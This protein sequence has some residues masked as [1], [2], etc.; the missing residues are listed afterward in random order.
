M[1]IGILIIILTV[2]T[3]FSANIFVR[4]Q[5]F[6]TGSNNGTDWNNAY[7]G[8]T[9]I[10][11]ASV[12]AGD[13]I[14]VAGGTYTQNLAPT[15]TG[16]SGSHI[17][18]SRARSDSTEC[19]S[20]SGW[21]SGFD[22]LITQTGGACFVFNGNYDYIDITGKTTASG[23]TDNFANY[24]WKIDM[25]GQT[26]GNG[27][28]VGAGGSDNCSLEWI[29]FQGVGEINVTGDNRAIDFT[30]NSTASGGW[31]FSHLSIHD[32]ESGVYLVNC[33]GGFTFEWIEMYDIAPLNT[34]TFHPN[35]IITWDAGDATVR[36]SKFHK[37]PNGLACG[38]GVFFEQS[39]GSTG[40]SIY[41]NIFYDIDY[42]GVKAIEITSAVGAIKIY[43]NTFVNVSVGTIYTSDSPSATGGNQVNNFVYNTSVSSVTGLT[44]ATNITAGGTNRFVNYSGKDFH[45]VSTT[46]SGYARDAGTAIAAPYNQDMDGNTRGADGSWDVGAFEYTAGGAAPT[47]SSATIDSAG[48][49]LTVVLSETCSNGSGGSG[50]WTISANGGGAQTATYSSGSG[51]STFIFSVPTVYQGQTVT[52]SYTQPG[53]GVENGSGTDLATFSGASVTNNSTQQQ[54]STPFG[55]ATVGRVKSFG[56]VTFK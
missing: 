13:K 31:R 51:S 24:G 1:R 41:G 8:F 43:N 4:P 52:V 29:E 20:A 2:H 16:T 37:G 44:S 17:T 35:G 14:W 49:Q 40:W 33:T 38:E 48:T 30:P 15:K 42:T 6:A 11:W 28:D 26:E 53:N 18:I 47:V 56:G 36:Y 21:S 9:A 55:S 22:S 32:W 54:P 34:A 7:K 45:I 3:A 46:G 25:S 50:G 27:L 10:S 5:S 19:T 23:G 39:G 12:A